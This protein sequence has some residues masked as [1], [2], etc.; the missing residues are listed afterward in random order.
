MLAHR[1]RSPYLATL[2]FPYQI[3]VTAAYL[4]TSTAIEHKCNF[5]TKLVKQPLLVSMCHILA[6][7]CGNGDLGSR[8]ASLRQPPDLAVA[9]WPDSR[10]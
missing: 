10:S 5:T 3:T 8:V 6:S 2:R 4:Q 7:V 9:A 1:V